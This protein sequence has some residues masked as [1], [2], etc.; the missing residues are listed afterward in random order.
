MPDGTRP[1]EAHQK[2]LEI[3]PFVDLRNREI[4]AEE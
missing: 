2:S 3:K 4:D 1:F